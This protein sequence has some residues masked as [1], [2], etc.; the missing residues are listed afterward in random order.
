[1]F[2]RFPSYMMSWTIPV[3]S[4]MT[5]NG[6]KILFARL[7]FGDPQ[8]AS[9]HHFQ[10]D[11]HQSNHS[12]EGN[13]FPV[14]QIDSGIHDGLDEKKSH[15]RR[16]LRNHQNL[17]DESLQRLPRVAQLSVRHRENEEGGVFERV[18]ECLR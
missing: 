18:L 7:V 16:S 14:Q 17:L 11:L 10:T 4:R 3:A 5:W 2:R 1:M 6:R 13:G 8:N 9:A 12:D 15:L